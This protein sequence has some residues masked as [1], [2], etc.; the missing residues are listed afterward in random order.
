ME[1]RL[2]LHGKQQKNNSISE[3]AITVTTM[4]HYVIMDQNKLFNVPSSGVITV[5]SVYGP[6]AIV[7]VQMT[8]L[9]V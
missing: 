9:Y 4:Q 1:S 7:Y 2:E 5:T 8:H 3:K 6:V